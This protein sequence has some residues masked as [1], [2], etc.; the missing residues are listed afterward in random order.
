MRNNTLKVTAS[1]DREIMMTRTFDAPR[2]LVFK[3]M[4]TPDL[5]RRWLGVHNGWKLDVCEIDL[6]VGGAYRYRWIGPD[7]AAMGMSGVYREVVRP[8]RIVCTEVFDEAWYPGEAVGT[9]VLTDDGERTKLT[10]TV[11]YDSPETRDAV[12]KTPMESGLTAGYDALE[13]V[14][15]AIPAPEGSEA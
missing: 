3:A 14:L 4:T 10:Q 5:V 2:P 9:L 12:L 8:E 13:D 15:A 1:G 6:K 11:R 7:G